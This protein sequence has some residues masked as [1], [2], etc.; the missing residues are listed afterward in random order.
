VTLG[1]Y[2][3]HAPIKAEMAVVGGFHADIHANRTTNS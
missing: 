1:D 3:S 2:E